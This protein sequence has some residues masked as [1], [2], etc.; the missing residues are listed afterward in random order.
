MKV[1]KEIRTRKST[2]PEEEK[3]KRPV[4]D[5]SKPGTR[6]ISI[7]YEQRKREMAEKALA[8]AEA[9]AA[10]ESSTVNDAP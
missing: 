2:T 4:V 3:P 10:A 9:C 7:Y 8:E 1:L 6:R 5:T